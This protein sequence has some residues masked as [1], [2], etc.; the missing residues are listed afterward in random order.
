[1][2]N[3]ENKETIKVAM[4]GDSSVGK[5]SILM[6]Y[7]SK[8]KC[9]I[10]TTPT[11]GVSF[12]Q[13]VIERNDKTVVELLISDIAGQSTFRDLLPLY[14]RGINVFLLV[15]D[16]TDIKTF[17]NIVEWS[18]LVKFHAPSEAKIILVGNKSD[19]AQIRVITSEQIEE[20]RMEIF[21]MDSF[22]CSAL[23]GENIDRLFEYI[24]SSPGI[25][26]TETNDYFINLISNPETEQPKSCIC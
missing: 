14:F 4:I 13:F 5:T 16:L 21:A 2:M 24:A 17:E 1:M 20:K 23:T 10:K 9:I 12:K 3:R 11:I 8:Q 7:E 22:E 26:R 25:P 18:Q 6:S 15:F 19:L